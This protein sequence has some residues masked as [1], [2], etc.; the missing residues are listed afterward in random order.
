MK[1]N[2]AKI[3]MGIDPAGSNVM[4]YELLRV[5]NKAPCKFNTHYDKLKYLFARNPIG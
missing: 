5:E 2:E 1:P 4:G 3:I